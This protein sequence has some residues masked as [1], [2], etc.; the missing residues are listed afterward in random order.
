MIESTE[1]KKVFPL[2]YDHNDSTDLIVGR[3][4]RFS[5]T[6]YEVHLQW[7]LFCCMNHV[8]ILCSLEGLMKDELECL[9]TK[10]AYLPWFRCFFHF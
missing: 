5:S 8:C 10:K 6:S 7:G 2:K 1:I 9:E 3:L 4:N